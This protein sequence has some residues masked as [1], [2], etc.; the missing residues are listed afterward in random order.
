MNNNKEELFIEQID[1]ANSAYNNLSST[2]DDMQLLISDLH[3]GIRMKMEVISAIDEGLDNHEEN[4]ITFLTNKICALLDEFNTDIDA[5]ILLFRTCIKESAMHHNKALSYFTGESQEINELLK[6]KKTLLYLITLMLKFRN[7][8]VEVT[9]SL[10]VLPSFSTEMKIQK[11]I[12]NKEAKL[13]MMELKSGEA[14]C[15][16]TAHLIDKSI[17]SK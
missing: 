2:Y 11:K 3:K 8:V 1:L 13:L 6:S 14:I 10:K 15:R 7:K 9:N 17:S 12:F 16:E 4:N 5:D